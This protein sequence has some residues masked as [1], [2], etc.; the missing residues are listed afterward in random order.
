MIGLALR[1]VL[2]HKGR[3]LLTLAAIAVGVAGMILSGGFIQDIFVQLGEAII[4]SQYGH[5]QIAKAGFFAQ[6]SRSPAKYFLDD[7]DA[8]RRAVATHPGVN[9]VMGRLEFSGLLNNGRTDLSIIGEGVEPDSEAPLGSYLQITAGRQMAQADTYGILLG[10]GVAHALKLAPGNRA[11]LVTN[12]VDGAANVLD[13]EVVG[14]FRSFSKDYD[15]RAVRIPLAA[16]QELLGTRAVNTLVVS[17][18]KTDDTDRVADVLRAQFGREAL[19]VMTWKALDDF[20]DKTVQMYDRQFGVLQLIIL[21]M[22]LLSVANTVNMAV[23]ERL[24]E[25]GT[26]R[27]LGNRALQVFGL[28]LTESLILGILGSAI[29]VAIAVLLA[30]AISAIGIP[31]PPPPNANLGYVAHILVVPNVVALAFAV[32]VSATLLAAVVPAARVART[33]VVTAL[34]ENV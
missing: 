5:V 16:A 15:A 13:F 12:T 29:G 31:M 7:P 18:L 25:F 4:H 24:G 10:E 19:D 14:I 23:F 21:A 3:T 11:T 9:G 8:V 1:N 17:L 34:R 6:G 28:V 33:P 2:R 30:W 20:Y 32:G 26:M 27:A 22:V